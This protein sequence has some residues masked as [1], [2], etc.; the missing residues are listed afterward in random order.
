[1]KKNFADRLNKAMEMRGM[2]PKDLA[3]ITG[4]DKGAISCY[5]SGKYKPAQKNTY[6]IS[7]ALQVNP[8][9]LMGSND[10]P[11]DNRNWTVSTMSDSYE[12]LAEVYKD[13]SDLENALIV[14]YRKADEKT[15]KVINTLLG[16]DEMFKE[17]EKDGRKA[18]KE[19]KN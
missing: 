5:R 15:K 12:Y 14:N 13:L 17:E 6:L 4:I 18:H 19:N 1:M 3:E 16:L 11:M 2:K 9:W 10:V 8:A 7:E